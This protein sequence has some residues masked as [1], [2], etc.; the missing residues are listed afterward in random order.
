MNNLTVF[1]SLTNIFPVLVRNEEHKRLLLHEWILLSNLAYISPY[2]MDANQYPE[3][4]EFWMWLYHES[5]EYVETVAGIIL[6]K[7]YVQS[8]TENGIFVPTIEMIQEIAKSQ[9]YKSYKKKQKL[10]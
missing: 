6:A 10:Q 1:N 4:L 9:F 8:R 5:E 3:T 2:Q 7:E